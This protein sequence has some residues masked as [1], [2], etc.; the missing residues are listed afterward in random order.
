MNR[1][2]Q[3]PSRPIVLL[4]AALLVANGAVLATRL[5]VAAVQQLQRGEHGVL[6]GLAC[7]QTQATPLAEVAERTKPVDLELLQLA[8]M[9][10]R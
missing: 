8:Q 9:L 4:L 7:G 3:A 1:L 6:I 10:A 2:P 5:G